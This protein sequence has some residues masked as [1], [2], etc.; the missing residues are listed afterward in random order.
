[1]KEKFSKS[2]IDEINDFILPIIENSFVLNIKSDDLSRITT[3]GDLS[4]FI[5]N[6]PDLKK[7]ND[8]TCQQAFYKL[9]NAISIVCK[10]EKEKIKPSS[11]LSDLI[12][13]NSR[14]SNV[15]EIEKQLNFKLFK[16]RPSKWQSYLLIF[17]TFFS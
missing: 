2:E 11:F 10:I 17:S 8:C 9:R 4:D 3:F 14:I 5:K 16:L 1:M 6:L 7:Y 13:K 12:P 15:L